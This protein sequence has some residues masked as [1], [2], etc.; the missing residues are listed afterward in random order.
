MNRGFRTSFRHIQTLFNLCGWDLASVDIA[1]RISNSSS[2]LVP[3]R[4]MSGA[5]HFPLILAHA[6]YSDGGVKVPG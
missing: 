1:L 6:I 3:G 5:K 4:Y 2:L